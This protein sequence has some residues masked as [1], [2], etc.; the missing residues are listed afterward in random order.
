MGVF[1]IYNVQ[2]L[3]NGVYFCFVFNIFVD[4]EGVLLFLVLRY[5]KEGI[6]TV[7]V[8]F[9]GNDVLCCVQLMLY[10]RMVFLLLYYSK[11]DIFK[12]LV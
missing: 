5:S 1:Q 3:D 9:L 6:F 2:D 11:E 4:V 12:V 8:L 7:F 10:L